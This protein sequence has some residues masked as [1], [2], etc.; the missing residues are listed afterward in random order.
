MIEVN[1]S[2]VDKVEGSDKRQGNDKTRGK[3]ERVG[4]A[5][6]A[7]THQSLVI[8]AQF[9]LGPQQE[10]S[11]TARSNYEWKQCS[12]ITRNVCTG[13]C[14][15]GNQEGNWR[16][17]V[18]HMEI[19]C[20]DGHKPR[21]HLGFLTS[22]RVKLPRC[23]D[24]ECRLPEK[25]RGSRRSEEGKQKEGLGRHHGSIESWH[26]STDGRM[27]FLSGHMCHSHLEARARGMLDME[28]W[29]DWTDWLNAVARTTDD[30]LAQD[31][32]APDGAPLARRPPS[33]VRRPPSQ[34][35]PLA[36]PPSPPPRSPVQQAWAHHPLYLRVFIPNN[37]AACTS[38]IRASAAPSETSLT[39]LCVSDR[40]TPGSSSAVSGPASSLAFVVVPTSA[41]TRPPAQQA[42]ARHPSYPIISSN[43]VTLWSTTSSALGRADT[44]RVLMHD[45][46]CG[47]CRRIRA[48]ALGMLVSRFP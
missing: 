29:R 45:G 14:Q 20:C 8:A 25:G 27:P 19:A 4:Q 23:G 12:L 7:R 9:S 21:T 3:I 13:A 11:R 32:C 31:V 47:H 1:L 24:S 33:Q 36:Q 40:N 38:S 48:C 18:H 46:A 37:S 26:R 16:Y 43:S 30:V 17:A 44:A 2:I 42:R 35:W 39:R 22:R 28:V 5:T 41:S 6:L 10:T 34:A 15:L